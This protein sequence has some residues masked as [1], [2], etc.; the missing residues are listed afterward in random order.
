MSNIVSYAK[1][2]TPTPVFNAN[3]GSE[4]IKIKTVCVLGK[5]FFT[6]EAASIKYLVVLSIKIKFASNRIMKQLSKMENVFATFRYINLTKMD[7]VLSALNPAAH[8]VAVKTNAVDVPT[9]RS[10]S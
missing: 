10:I 5:R 4:E 1:L 2:A 6:M 7:I 3:K 9:L 8:N